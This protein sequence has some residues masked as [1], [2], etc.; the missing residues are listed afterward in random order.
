MLGDV[1]RPSRE[2]ITVFGNHDGLRHIKTDSLSSEL[3]SPLRSGG[4][5]ST[6]L[7]RDSHENASKTPSEAFLRSL[8][9]LNAEAVRSRIA[10]QTSKTDEP[11]SSRTFRQILRSNLFTRFNALV[12]VL[13]VVIAFVGPPLDAVFGAVLVGY[14]AIG[15][16][17]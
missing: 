17:N 11:R 10:A 9:G 2:E 16:V 1:S 4:A 6:T 14:A 8:N 13:L 15:I 5:V 3:A 12:G 7:G